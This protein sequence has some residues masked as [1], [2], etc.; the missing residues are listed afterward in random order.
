MEDQVSSVLE[1]FE[2]F[3]EEAKTKYLGFKRHI[4]T[5]DILL[6]VRRQQRSSARDDYHLCIAAVEIS[7]EYWGKGYFKKLI[8]SIESNIGH[9]SSIEFESVNSKHLEKMLRDNGYID[10]VFRGSI[11]EA[12]NL[13]KTFS[14][15]KE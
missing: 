4:L 11:P 7:E 14:K 15:E 9:F 6:F 10:S 12:P 8:T 5:E 3:K 2:E 13:S 1:Q